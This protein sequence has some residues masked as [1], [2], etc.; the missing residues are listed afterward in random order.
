MS[1]IDSIGP[2]RLHAVGEEGIPWIKWA[3]DINQ[4]WIEYFL[5]MLAFKA[6]ITNSITMRW[7][8]SSNDYNMSYSH[9]FIHGLLVDDTLEHYTSHV[10]QTRT[11]IRNNIGDGFKLERCIVES[12]EDGVALLDELNS[13]WIH[14]RLTRDWT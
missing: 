11:I 9:D 4:L 1:V 14:Y 7:K 5:P 2:F 3:S 12:D 13:A 6:G 8:S 10:L